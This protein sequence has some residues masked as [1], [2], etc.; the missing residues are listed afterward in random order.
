[1]AAHPGKAT[2]VD[3]G[4]P[5]VDN[6]SNLPEHPPFLHRRVAVVEKWTKS[7][8]N[9]LPPWFDRLTTSGKIPFVLSL[10]KD[11]G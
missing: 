11:R 5:H 7:L 4:A 3:S 6:F 10:S 8:S 1:M 2:F 9:N